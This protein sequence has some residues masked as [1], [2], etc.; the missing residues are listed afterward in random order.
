MSARSCFH[1]PASTGL[2]RRVVVT[3]ATLHRSREFSHAPPLQSLLSYVFTNPPP[4]TLLNK[5]DLVYVLRPGG[6]GGD[7]DGDL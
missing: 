2:S 6:S 3:C 4:D 1:N 7:D 5:H